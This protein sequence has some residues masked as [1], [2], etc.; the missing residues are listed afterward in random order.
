M[1]TY[2]YERRMTALRVQAGFKGAMG[3]RANTWLRGQTWTD[4]TA[5]QRLGTI[6][7]LIQYPSAYFVILLGNLGG[8]ILL[9]GLALLAVYK[10]IVWIRLIIQTLRQVREIAK[11]AQTAAGQ[12]AVPARP[13]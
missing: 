4:L 9:I 6:T 13:V 5:K 1:Y 2:V 11:E 3:S 8:Q 7:G 10:H 12:G